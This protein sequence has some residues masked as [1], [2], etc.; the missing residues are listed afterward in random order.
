VGHSGDARGEE[1]RLAAVAVAFA[2]AAPARPWQ[3]TAGV[4][5]AMA[6]VL[7]VA[8]HRSATRRRRAVAQMDL[9]LR[10]RS[11]SEQRLQALLRHADDVVAVLTPAGRCEY[12][13]S[14]ADRV[15]GVPWGE[16]RGHTLESLLGPAA[17][18]VLSELAAVVRLP[19]MVASSEVAYAHPDG[20]ARVLHAVLSN[21]THD[22]A[23]SGVVLNISDVTERRSYEQLL[24]HQASHDNLTGLVNRTQLR[25]LLLR[26]WQQSVSRA[27]T[28]AVLFA[29][30]DGFKSV[31]DDFG[32]DIGDVLLRAVA[33]RIRHAIRG[34]DI[35]VRYGGD[36]FL[37][38]CPDTD[39]TVAELVA[40]RLGDAVARP[41]VIG[42]H[43]IDT[44]VSVGVAIAD[45]PV[46]DV[47]ALVR[48]ADEA[49]YVV[50]GPRRR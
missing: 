6:A 24:A 16:V 37:V 49:M 15:L 23:V 27:S 19:G 21:L 38:V 48:C 25:D 40:Q 44:G 11:A 20:R 2:T 32:H 47:D 9:A 26:T 33:D 14:S 46:G 35:A 3:I 36:E 5:V 17:A 39:R 4:A 29:D 31:N 41:V 30:L 7:A 43:R 12:V 8:A 1:P 50:K 22:L 13:S 42:P 34:G 45:G 28:F 18:P 10:D